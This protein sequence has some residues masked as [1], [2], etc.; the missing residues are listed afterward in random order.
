VILQCFSGNA[1][2][3]TGLLAIKYRLVLSRRPSGDARTLMG[4]CHNRLVLLRCPSGNACILTSNAPS[5][6]GR[7]GCQ[8]VC[9]WAAIVVGLPLLS[10]YHHCRAAIIALFPRATS[11]RLICCWTTSSPYSLGLPLNTPFV[12]IG[13]TSLPCSLSCNHLSTY[14]ADPRCLFICLV[15]YLLLSP[16]L[17]RTPPPR[18]QSTCLSHGPS[19]RFK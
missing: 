17:P 3:L 7:H 12:V 8:A 6:S 11:K 9:C 10:G 15:H 18:R 14:P 19:S 13:L 16:C 5:L 2:I 4:S 1:C